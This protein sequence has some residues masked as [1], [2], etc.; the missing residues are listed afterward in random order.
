MKKLITKLRTLVKNFGK[1]EELVYITVTLWIA[2]GILG[3][4]KG[5]NFSQL[6]MYFGALTAYVATYIWGE[7][8]R[9]SEKTGIMQPGPSS[10]RE[11][12]IYVIVALWSIVGAFAIWYK[13]NLSD[14][15]VYFVSLTGFVASWIAGEVYKP[16]DVVKT[17]NS[18]KPTLP[19]MPS[20]PKKSDNAPENNAI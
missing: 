16:Q 2:M 5:V 17:A 20:M 6:G 19:G 14:L 11:V 4:V 1:R 3:A 13:A 18:N 10:R 8:R 12:M 7:S 9:P 15:A